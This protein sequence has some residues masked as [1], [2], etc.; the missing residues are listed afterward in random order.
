MSDTRKVMLQHVTHS[1]FPPHSVPAKSSV[2][3]VAV[4]AI[5]TLQ[6]GGVGTQQVKLNVK[7][8]G[9]VL[10][11]TSDVTQ[12]MHSAMYPSRPCCVVDAPLGGTCRVV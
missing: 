11:R 12:V 8:S 4:A 3:S 1:R 7:G 5:E 2:A 6:L 10:G 9:D